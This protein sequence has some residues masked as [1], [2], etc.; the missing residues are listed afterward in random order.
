MVAGHNRIR[1]DHHSLGAAVHSMGCVALPHRSDLHGSML[2]HG[3]M[4]RTLFPMAR[5]GELPTKLRVADF[6]G[7]RGDNPRLAAYEDQELHPDVAHW[8]TYLGI[9]GVGVQLHTARTLPAARSFY[10]SRFDG[11]RCA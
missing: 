9:S 8:W 3:G 6:H 11:R 5:R 2:L 7:L 1:H 4:G 10:G